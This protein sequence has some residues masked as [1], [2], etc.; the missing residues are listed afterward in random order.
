MN[1]KAIGYNKFTCLNEADGYLIAG[2]TLK[3]YKNGVVFFRNF[4]SPCVVNLTLA[5]ELYLK[6]LI[7]T[8]GDGKIE[9]I[10]HL[11]DLF[12]KLPDT[13]KSEIETDY[14]KWESPLSFDDCISV[15]NDSFVDIRYLYEK[16]NDSSKSFE[17]SS[18]YNLAVALHN[19]SHKDDNVPD[20]E[21]QVTDYKEK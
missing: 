19:V 17:P 7:L 6:C 15:H 12:Q 20:S 5:C 10:H 13:I 16:R 18:L 4:V 21:E 9:H 8:K 2:K 1:K 3:Y 11:S 14:N